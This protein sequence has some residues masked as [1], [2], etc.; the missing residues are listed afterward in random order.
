MHTY[1]SALAEK[2]REIRGDWFDNEIRRE[3]DPELVEYYLRTALFSFCEQQDFDDT[4]ILDFGSGAGASTIV[5]SRLLPSSSFVGVELDER[6][7][8]LARERAAH[9]GIKAEF[10][11]SPSPYE[12]PDDLG[13]FDFVVLN[14][15]WEHL[16][17]DERPI[18]L[19]RLLD[20][21]RAEGVLFI[22]E[23]PHRWFP[24]EFHTTGLPL[25]N[26]VPP[27][28]ALRFARG[29]RGLAIDISWPELLRHGVRGGTVREI[30]AA[31]KGR[32]ATIPPRQGS[33]G[34]MW[35]ETSPHRRLVRVKAILSR[36]GV[37]PA[38]TVALRKS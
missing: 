9:H 28:L 21:L 30:R 3:T 16:L 27:P 8:T 34:R 19:N 25:L 13:V 14:A 38:V 2:I 29:R 23:T 6:L 35:Y 1:P 4:R 12:L 15:V 32:A 7:V 37:I 33:Y 26:Y 11:T 31:A 10:H 24:M 36:M 17:P 22:S 18:L 5:L 20:V